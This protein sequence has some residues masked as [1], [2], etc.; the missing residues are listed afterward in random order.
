MSESS[1]K[2]EVVPESKA[3][4]HADGIQKIF[5]PG[6]NQTV[7]LEHIDLSLIHI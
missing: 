4:V 2:I 6:P 3:Y 1:G 7:A 5:N